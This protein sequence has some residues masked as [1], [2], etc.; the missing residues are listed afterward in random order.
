MKVTLTD[1]YL[2]SLRPA[3]KGKRVV[4]WDGASPSFG[5]RVTD[6]GVVSFFVQRRQAGKPTPVRVTLGT[7][8]HT[9]LAQ[10]RVAAAGAL[11]ALVGGDHPRDLEKRARRV[12]AD[13]EAKTFG[14][15]ADQFIKR[16]VANLRSSADVKSAIER[17]L[18]PRWGD[19][20]ITD[21]T[22][23]DVIEVIEDVVQ[24]GHPRGAGLLLAYTRKLFNWAMARDLIEHSPC[25]KVKAAD[26]IGT[27]KPR[28]RTLT[29]TELKALWHATAG[30]DYPLNP[31]IRLLVVTGARRSEVARMTRDELDLDAGTWSL[32]GDRTKNEDPRILALPALAVGVLRALPEWDGPFVFSTTGG[33]RPISAFAKL[34]ARLDGRLAIA[35]WRLHDLRRTMR[36]HLSALRIEQHVRELMIGH[37]QHGIEGVY[38]VHAYASEQRDGFEQWTARLLRIVE[39]TSARVVRLRPK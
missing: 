20:P 7:Y 26:L 36:T 14:G 11:K 3:P 17:Q 9:S 2:K 34:K 18:I 27:T 30:E 32:G 35:R 23:R 6:C 5:L 1:R 19:R 31:F 22:R 33:K 24:R 37:R 4:V 15:I 28:Q 16:H 21:I 25:D 39:P 29:D 8:P 38:D 12:R 10:A 13:R